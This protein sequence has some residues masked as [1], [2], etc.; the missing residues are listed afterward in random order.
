M[1]AWIKRLAQDT[2]ANV[3]MI[4][5]L[6]ATSMV[7]AAGMGVDTVQWFLWKR[8]LQQAVDSGAMAGAYSKHN[9][10]AVT[11]PAKNEIDRN[12]VDTFTVV[13]IGTPKSGD[14]KDD[15]TAVEVI[16]QTSRSL[17]FSSLFFKTAPTIQ[18]RS[19]AATVAGAKHC[20]IA[21]AKD[22][23][24][25]YVHGTADVNLGCGAAANSQV[26]S[27]VD[28]TGSS[29]L[30]ADP[31]SAVGGISYG[32]QNIPNDTTL[33][34]YGLEV[35]D[36]L[37][38]RNLSAPSSPAGCSENNFA[39]Q[40]NQTLTI[41][42]GRYCNG[43]S[44]KGKVTMSP[45]VYI[46]DRGSFDVSSQAKVTGEGVTIVLTGT[47]ASN[48]ADIKING[49]AELDLRAPTKTEDPEWY[50]ILFYQDPLGSSVENVING[51]SALNFE[52]VV[53]FPSG[54]VRFNGN[55]GQHADCLLLVAQ[56]VNFSGESSLDNDCGSDY[57]EIKM[58]SRII[59]VVE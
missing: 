31:I 42:P 27:A 57:D 29:V 56:R 25:I 59:R 2:S 32:S 8:Q 21:L 19:V 20:V 43:L 9:G 46:I 12:F 55:A 30:R 39:V 52:G 50:N 54:N 23:T 48:V 44:L 26:A 53:Y 5:A 4:S 28:L 15:T 34:P 35:E 16:A 6:G 10:I 11:D 37:G 14:F 17:P 51:G 24:G 1:F 33:L 36:P 7:G 40:P 13:S 58:T 47:T 38:S 22:G 3:L 18:V 41:A 49:G 45:G